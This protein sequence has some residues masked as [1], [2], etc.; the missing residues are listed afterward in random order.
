MKHITTWLWFK[1]EAE[2][3]VDYY[4]SIFQSGQIM[5]KYYIPNDQNVSSVVINFKIG[6][7][8]L[9]AFNGN[10]DYAKMSPALSLK[11]T[12]ETEDELNKLWVELSGNTRVIVPL[13]KRSFT[14]LYGW[15]IDKY[16]VSWQLNLNNK[17]QKITPHLM[18]A[19]G[20][21]MRSYE[22][23]EF[24]ANIF[25]DAIVSKLDVRPDNKVKWCEIKIND[26]TM[27]LSD[28][29]KDNDYTFSDAISIEY[30]CKDQAEI[31]RIWDSL[32]ADGGE[33]VACFWLRDKFGLSWQI[34][35]ED[36][37]DLINGPNSDKVL[38]V[39]Q[40]MTKPIIAD[41]LKASE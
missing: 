12:C 23:V 5:E 17:P 39:V 7:L 41:L 33:E 36:F 11:V 1:D 24:Y 21:Y 10:L 27:T 13:Q 30:D 31:D 15:C 3:A 6:D 16:G 9:G 20:N 29:A 19:N 8:N 38:A 35:P 18:F 26:F 2:D 37:Y 4:M 22:A 34:I 28:S 40:T 14:K 25:G 32:I